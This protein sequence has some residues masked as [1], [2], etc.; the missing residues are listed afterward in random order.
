MAAALVRFVMDPLAISNFGATFAAPSIYAFMFKSVTGVEVGPTLGWA[1]HLIC[2][3]VLVPLLF[4]TLSR[5]T[6]RFGQALT[7][8]ATAMAAWGLLMAVLMPA[9]GLPFFYAFSL[10]TVWSGV[11]FAILGLCLAL[12]PS[13][14]K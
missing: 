13:F 8:F 11:A 5:N 3:L 1:A 6:G 2:F 10:T 9:A 7:A 14:F 12:A 4:V